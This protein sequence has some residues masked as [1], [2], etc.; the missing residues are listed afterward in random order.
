[1]V[2]AF[3]GLACRPPP[4]RVVGT[5]RR[6]LDT[7]EEDLKGFPRPH[8]SHKSIHRTPSPLPEPI[9]P[10]EVSPDLL[11]APFHVSD[12]CQQCC[13]QVSRGYDREG[14]WRGHRPPRATTPLTLTPCPPLPPP[15]RA[16]KTLRAPSLVVQVLP[17]DHMSASPPLWESCTSLQ[18][19]WTPL[20]VK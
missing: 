20:L 2:V 7:D 8:P 17:C 12:V 19:S 1:M 11:S 6:R 15:A 16:L 10:R 3:R 14:P 9:H 5:S 13:H 4:G 18:A